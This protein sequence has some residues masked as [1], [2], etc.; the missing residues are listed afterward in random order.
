MAIVKFAFGDLDQR[1]AVTQAA[2]HAPVDN[3][4]VMVTAH[5]GVVD[6]FFNV[7]TGR[8]PGA[9]RIQPAAERAQHQAVGLY[10][11][12]HVRGHA[13]VRR[14]VSNLVS[15]AVVHGGHEREV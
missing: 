10:G 8:L 13:E 11:L 4:H 9:A 12:G 7:K 14:Q 3:T 15:V 6:P 2:Q 1:H 5:S